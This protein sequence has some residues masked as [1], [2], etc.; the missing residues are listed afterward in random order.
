MEHHP[1][2]WDLFLEGYMR[3]RYFKS[4]TSDQSQFAFEIVRGSINIHAT[5][6]N[7]RL[8]IVLVF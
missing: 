3:G 4:L 5:L 2:F 6:Y 7:Y 1:L 8:S